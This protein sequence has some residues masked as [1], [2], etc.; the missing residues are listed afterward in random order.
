MNEITSTE[1]NLLL[2]F[3]RETMPEHYRPY[4]AAKRNNFF[5]GV[6]GSPNLWRFFCL[7]DMILFVEFQDM[8][9]PTDTNS[10]VPLV[11]FLNAHAKIRISMELAFSRCMEEARSILRDAIETAVFAHFML[12]EPNMQKVWLSKDN[13]KKEADEF[14]EAFEKDKRNKTFK[15]QAKLYEQWGHLSETGAHSTPQA[16]VSRFIIKESGQDMHFVLNYTGVE[17]RIWEP[18]M[19]TLLLNVSQIEQMVFNDFIKRLQFDEEL[20]RNR[21]IAEQLQK[22]C[23][24][25]LITKHNIQPPIR[26][27]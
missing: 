15:G 12:G 22:L 25:E 5:A 23:L 19:F 14:K 20:L 4:F 1:D 24:Q 10:M 6:Q 3:E 2:P 16:V 11:L 18:E 26:K 13:G 27:P 21:A 9:R 8:V 17:D 7:L